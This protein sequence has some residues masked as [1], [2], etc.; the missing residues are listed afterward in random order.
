MAVDVETKKQKDFYQMMAWLIYNGAQLTAIGVNNPKEFPALEDIF[1]N[2]FE[3][4]DQQDWWIMKE[5][6]EEYRKQMK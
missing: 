1:P 3:K 6:I 2:L 4:K 5:R